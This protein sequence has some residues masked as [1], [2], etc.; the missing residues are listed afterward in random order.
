MSEP[1]HRGRVLAA[2][3]MTMALVAMDATIIATALL[4]VVTDLGGMALLGWVFSGYLLGMCVAIPIFGKFADIYGRKPVIIAGSLLFLLSSALCATAWDMPSLIAFRILQGI[5][6][7]GITATIPTIASDLYGI[8]ERGRAQGY[9]SSVWGVAS[10]AGPTLGGAFAEYATWRWIFLINLPIGAVALLLLVRYLREDVE[11]HRHRIDFAGATGVLLTAGTLIFALLQGGVAWPWLSAPSIALFTL[12]A[13]FA[14]GTVLLEK[15]AVEPIVP[16][17]LVRRRALAAT[18]FASFAM[19][20]LII[21]PAPYVPAYG[22]SVLGLTTIAAGLLLAVMS[23]SW[24]IAASQSAR[25]YLRLGFRR[26]GLIGVTLCLIGT[27]IFWL[28]PSGTVAGTL[29]AVFVM[30]GGL[31]LL[32][33]SLLVGAQSA[34]DWGERGTVTGVIMFSR[35]VGQSVGA[36][37]LGAV[38]NTSLRAEL[39]AAPD[40]LA[41]SMPKHIDDITPTLNSPDTTERVAEFIRDAVEAATSNVF[42]GLTI[43][44][45]VC[46]AILLLAMPHDSPKGKSAEGDPTVT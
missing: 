44:A 33:I 7:A 9:L 37:I 15:R 29:A 25:F 22:Q 36:A 28:Q 32:T 34:V 27:M 8:R 17:V 39:A 42:V 30:G 16:P 14:G 6:G 40:R 19:G 23:V 18:C 4:D 12:T 46:G 3:M 31:G 2:L 24:P 5:G 43:C 26:T 11:R 21:G 35:F 38:A 13:L 10:L 45:L 1:V 41:D 20:M